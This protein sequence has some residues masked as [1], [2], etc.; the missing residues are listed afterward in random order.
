MVVAEGMY[1]KHSCNQDE[2]DPLI[3]TSW[4]SIGV[5]V[6]DASKKSRGDQVQ[7]DNCTSYWHSWS[8]SFAG[9]HLHKTLS[10]QCQKFH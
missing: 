2:T 7:V 3:L 8:I 5:K 10:L 9:K 4:V 6:K 1:S